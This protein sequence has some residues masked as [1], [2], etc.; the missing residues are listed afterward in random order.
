MKFFFSHN[1]FA[2]SKDNFMQCDNRATH[3]LLKL[4]LSVCALL[5]F[6][7][8]SGTST[9][10]VYR[11][12]HI[13]CYDRAINI[14]AFLACAVNSTETRRQTTERDSAPVTSSY[15]CEFTRSTPNTELHQACIYIRDTIQLEHGNFS[16]GKERDIL[17][18]KW[19]TLKGRRHQIKS[20]YIKIMPVPLQTEK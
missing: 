17:A 15:T 10:P 8:Q 7:T 14:Q 13:L 20:V 18:I 4:K 12:M 9:T 1:F 2:M 16:K 5:L 11:D 3:Q 6:P 19:D